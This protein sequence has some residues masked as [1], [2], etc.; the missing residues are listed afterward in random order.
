[1][2]PQPP[3]FGSMEYWDGRFTSNSNPFEWLDAPTVLD[4]YLTEALKDTKEEKPELLHIGCGTSLLSYHLRAHVKEPDQIHNLDYSSVAVDVGRKREVEIYSVGEKHEEAGPPEAS[5]VVR[6]S[7][8]NISAR[9]SDGQCQL[10][11]ARSESVSPQE[12]SEPKYMRWSAANLLSHSSLLSVCKPSAYSVIVDKSTSDS[13]ACADDPY[14]F[15]PYPLSTASNEPLPSQV[16]RSSEPIQPVHI[17]A[18]HLAVLTK[19][20]ARWIALSYSE[21]RYPFLHQRFGGS[22]P[23]S[24]S[25]SQ[26]KTSSTPVP[27]STLEAERA[28]DGLYGQLDHDLDDIPDK[29]FDMG[30]PD[31]SKLWRLVNKYEI[32][33]PPP[34]GSPGESPIVYR[35]KIFHWVYIL[36]R[37]DVEVFLRKE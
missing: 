24:G 32:E 25:T 18:I 21:D 37:T 20:R 36:E 16:E 9:N 33:V 4:P 5:T 26:S 29:V 17:L 15:L 13:I 12:R 19:P 28:S 23:R 7:S 6:E 30:L 2:P 31:P 11:S 22:A 1:M 27:G 3:S 34:Q 10:T 8:G 35:P 14:V